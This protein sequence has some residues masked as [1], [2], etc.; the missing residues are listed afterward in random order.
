MA[1]FGGPHFARPTLLVL[2][3]FDGAGCVGASLDTPYKLAIPFAL[4]P[5]ILHHALTVGDNTTRPTALTW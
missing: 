3:P 4:A 1:Y 2:T 5:G